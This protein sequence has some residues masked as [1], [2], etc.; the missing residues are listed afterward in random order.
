MDSSKFFSVSSTAALAPAAREAKASIFIMVG[1]GFAGCGGGAEGVSPRCTGRGTRR[2]R[3]AEDRRE[4][5]ERGRSGLL[6]RSWTEL[7]TG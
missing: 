1:A 5:G 3:G 6:A 4:Q 7:L 2:G